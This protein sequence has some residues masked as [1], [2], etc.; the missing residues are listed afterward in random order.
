MKLRLD[1]KGDR[2][3]TENVILEIKAAA[4][5]LGLKIAG[6]EVVRGSTTRRKAR[7][8]VL[9]RSSMSRA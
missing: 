2:R 5:R 7:K 9:R 8:P 1:L 3:W 6:V 4:R